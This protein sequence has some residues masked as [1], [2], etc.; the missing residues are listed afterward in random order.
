MDRA[1]CRAQSIFA[2]RRSCVQDPNEAR[3]KRPVY[4]CGRFAGRDPANRDSRD[5]DPDRRGP[6]DST[7]L[8]RG[9]DDLSDNRGPRVNWRLF[10]VASLIMLAFSVWALVTPVSAQSTM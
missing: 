7:E 4:E 6:L 2:Y 1:P 8:R 5:A 3:L 10:I 9:P